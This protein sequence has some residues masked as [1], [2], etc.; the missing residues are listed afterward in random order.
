LVP[1]VAYALVLANAGGRPFLEELYWNNQFGRFF[2]NYKT[3]S[4]E[5]HL[6]LR[7]W[8]ELVFP[9][10]PFAAV[11][12]WR[13]TLAFRPERDMGPE[14]RG[15]HVE[16]KGGPEDV[17]RFLA[18]WA[19]V[20]LV[21]LSA[22]QARARIY[23]LPVVPAYALLVALA[24]RSWD[25]P[26]ARTL[27]G[28][29]ALGVALTVV[30]FVVALG[31]TS[32]VDAL[33][34]GG[35]LAALAI[36]IGL[37]GRRARGITPERE[38]AALLVCAAVL[39]GYFVYSGS[40][41][42]RQGDLRSSYRPLADDVWRRVQGRRLVQ[43]HMNDSYSGTFSF[44]ADRDTPIFDEIGDAHG[45]RLLA[46]IGPNDVVIAPEGSLQLLDPARRAE[47]VVESRYVR[48]FDSDRKGL[49]LFRKRRPDER[50]GP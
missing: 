32:G 38:T 2:H 46:A 22:S 24:W 12:L 41:F 34:L 49:A 31:V 11:A 43:F 13:A 35:G 28:W 39:A 33:E 47:L 5:W 3:K 4:S 45:E 1:N 50:R 17:L 21:V 14:G 23:A 9:W 18:L 44:Y 36:A 6:Y 26:R 48:P 42:A 27:A 7:T 16:S 10:T 20:P 29:L 30:T 19:V 37:V 25:G 15:T 40:F 8:W